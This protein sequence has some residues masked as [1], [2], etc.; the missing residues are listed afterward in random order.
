MEWTERVKE[1]IEPVER[2][3]SIENA[4]W[5]KIDGR[6]YEEK[7]AE[8]RERGAR[9]FHNI[10]LNE[11]RAYMQNLWLNGEVHSEILGARIYRQT[12]DAAFCLTEKY[13]E[14]YV[15]RSALH[16]EAEHDAEYIIRKSGIEIDDDNIFFVDKVKRVI[17]GV[18]LD[19]M[20]DGFWDEGVVCGRNP[21]YEVAEEIVNE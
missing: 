1:V 16:T 14:D 6:V 4:V 9:L 13:I 11:A 20:D 18:L 3:R 8:W 19:E 21:L 2:I 7:R 10:D 15:E 5:E 17:T 12:G